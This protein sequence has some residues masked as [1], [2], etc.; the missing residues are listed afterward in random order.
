MNDLSLNLASTLSEKGSTFCS[1]NL[2]TDESKRM[3]FNATVD[4][5]KRLSD[6]INQT[7]VLKDVYAESVEMTDNETG[8]INSGV[9]IILFDKD[10]VSYQTTSSGIFNAIGRIIA[11]FGRPTWEEGIA[12]TVKQIRRGKGNMLTLNLA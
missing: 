5:D 2:L 1:V 6:M 9:R 8:E 4:P 11:L 3:V 12:V 7:I 10:G